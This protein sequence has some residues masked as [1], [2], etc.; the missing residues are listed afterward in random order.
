MSGYGDTEALWLT[1]VR[2]VTGFSAA[3]TSRGNYKIL[4]NGTSE[5]YVVLK[6]GEHAREM[7]SLKN[8]LNIWQTIIEIH[9]KYRDDGSSLTDLQANYD[10]LL[11]SLDEYPR[12]GDTGNTVRKAEVT[13]VAEVLQSPADAPSWL[14]AKIIGTVDEEIPI[15]FQE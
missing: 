8:R 4:N 13:V 11:T 2:A 7:A 10:T 15:N 3:N 5:V 9:Q 6:P 1:R 12:M 14:I